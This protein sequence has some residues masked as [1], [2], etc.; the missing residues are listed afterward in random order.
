MFFIE[1]FAKISKSWHKDMVIESKPIVTDKIEFGNE[2]YQ[3]Q[4][5][6]LQNSDYQDFNANDP[7]KWFAID[8]FS[9]TMKLSNDTSLEEIRNVL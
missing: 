3:H 1:W 2:I 4:K 7:N 5:R 6:T 8:S 9:K